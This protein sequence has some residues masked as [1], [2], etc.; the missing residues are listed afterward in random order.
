MAASTEQRQSVSSA[1][2]LLVPLGL[3]GVTGVMRLR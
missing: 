3:V 2:A 1:L